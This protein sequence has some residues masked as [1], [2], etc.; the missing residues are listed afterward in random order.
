MIVEAMAAGLP[1]VATDAG[2]VRDLVGDAGAIVAGDASDA[3]LAR[4]LESV[5]DDPPRRAAMAAKGRERVA[6][7]EWDA[8]AEALE[9][10]LF[11]GATGERPRCPGA[12]TS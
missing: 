8:Q 2:G 7:W 10:E 5:I 12:E 1:I 3:E 9:R 6:P 11:G 4:A